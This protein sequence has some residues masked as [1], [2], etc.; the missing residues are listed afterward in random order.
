LAKK[1]LLIGRETIPRL[2]LGRLGNLSPLPLWILLL[3]LSLPYIAQAQ[4]VYITKTGSKYHRDNCRYLSKSKFA[5]DLKEAKAHGYTPCSVCKPSGNGAT[6]QPQG[7]QLQKQPTPS[8]STRCTAT[9][10]AGTRCS[11]TTTNPNGRC[12]QHQ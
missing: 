12:W 3:L 7:Q 5:T 4:T 2:P 11:R 10:K 1:N 8:A 9:T 6:I